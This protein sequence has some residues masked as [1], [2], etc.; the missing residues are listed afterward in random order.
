MSFRHKTSCFET[1]IADLL[2]R[3]GLLLKFC[4]SSNFRYVYPVDG[5]GCLVIE[6]QAWKILIR[7]EQEDG[8]SYPSA[9]FCYPNWT[10]MSVTSNR[11]I[12]QRYSDRDEKLVIDKRFDD[13]VEPFLEQWA[14]EIKMLSLNES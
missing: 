13:R 11:G 1:V 14:Q 3:E 2:E 5:Y 6:R 9:Q 10:C 7:I 8:S 4:R 12:Y